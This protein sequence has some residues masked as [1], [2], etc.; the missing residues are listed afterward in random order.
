MLASSARNPAFLRHG[1]THSR[2]G[3]ARPG[4]AL[5]GNQNL[6][7][8]QAAKRALQRGGRRV[9]TR[10]RGPLPFATVGG[11]PHSLPQA[12]EPQAVLP[13]AGLLVDHRSEKLR[14][15]VV[16]DL[17]RPLADRRVQTRTHRPVGERPTEAKRL[18]PR[19]WGGAVAR[20]QD[21]GALRQHAQK[22]VCATH[23]VA[24]CSERRR[25]L[26]TRIS[27]G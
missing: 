7:W 14:Q 15:A 23:Q 26:V 25:S 10:R 3:A 2:A 12:Q 22:G 27:G 13:P 4:S 19:S 5:E 6:L 18:R 16:A 24:T 11:G 20:K 9:L 8:G 21:G 17:F 1:E